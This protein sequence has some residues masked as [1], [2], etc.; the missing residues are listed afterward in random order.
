VTIAITGANSGVGRILLRHLAARADIKVVACVRSAQAAAGLPAVHGMSVRAIEYGDRDGLAAALSGAGCVV[1]L[2]GIL[3]ESPGSSYE[4]AN[5]DATRAVVDACKRTGVPR[6]V[7][8]SV[9]GAD[10]K[11]ANRYLSSKGRA[12]RIVSG[13]GLSAAII[14]TPILLGPGMAAARAIVDRASQPTVTLLGGGRHS[15]CPL[16][17]D[18]LSRALLRCCERPGAEAALYELVG[19]ESAAYRDVVARTAALMG[20]DVSIRSVPVWLARLGAAIAS[21]TRPGGMTPTV[22]DVITASEAVHENAAARLGVALTP[23]AATLQKLVPPQAK[24]AR[25]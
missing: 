21:W 8:V 16:D 6:V 4:T 13:S 2:A 20:H 15:I 12:E 14:R 9:L 7:L 18:D 11:S 24:A 1:H 25:P 3:F 5:V 10:P 22:I 19:P 23:L 17:V